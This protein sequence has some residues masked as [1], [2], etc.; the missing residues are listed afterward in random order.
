MGRLLAYDL[1][2]VWKGARAAFSKKRDILLLLVAVPIVALVAAQ[3]A[4]NAAATVRDIAE[5]AKMLLVAVTA[6]FVNLA[7]ERRLTHLELE[8]VVARFA[9]RRAPRLVHRLFW[10]AL[11]LVASI[12]IMA[13]GTASSAPLPARV[14]AL[15][16]AYSAGAGAGALARRAQYHLVR[17]LSR[18]R[19]ASGSVR[20]LRLPG[21]D[22]R[23]R[24]AALVA[25][26]TGLAGPSI[27]ANA[28]AFAVIG[29]LV[30]LL[31][32]L[33]AGALPRPGP[34]VLAAV[35]ATVAFGLL[36]RQHPPLLRYLL[37]LGIE[38]ARP[39]LV[40]AAS[41]GSLAAGFVLTAAAL[42]LPEA[43]AFAV[44]AACAVRFSSSSLCFERFI[45]RPDP[46]RPRSWRCRSTRW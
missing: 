2:I 10:N 33:S 20:L 28:A 7:A 9:L 5:P 29:A 22:R 46:A 30:A 32:R 25:A 41:A 11:P 6:L 34:E 40:P 17:R 23:Q 3:G 39:A 26:R 18:R 14:A 19:S 21:D 45:T 31:Y 43:L 44:L 35:A 38:P 4:S 8:S 13:A 15:V 12:S 42:N 1:L 16:L 24:I 36:L 27:A 37:Y